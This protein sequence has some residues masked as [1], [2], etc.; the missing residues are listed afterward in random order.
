MIRQWVTDCSL[1]VSQSIY[2]LVR[3]FGTFYFFFIQTL[4]SL[5][6]GLNLGKMAWVE[7]HLWRFIILAVVVANAILFYFWM[8]P[9]TRTLFV[10]LAL[11]AALLPVGLWFGCSYE[12]YYLTIEIMT[13][14]FESMGVLRLSII[15]AR[16]L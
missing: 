12:R 10:F 5:V 1:L 13:H 3:I 7:P 15:Q 14:P 6:A 11:S 8:K 2:S 16:G 9:S 4:G